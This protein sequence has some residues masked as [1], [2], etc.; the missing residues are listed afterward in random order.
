M[1]LYGNVVIDK[2][3]L[4]ANMNFSVSW[5]CTRMCGSIY[6][7]ILFEKFMEYTSVNTLTAQQLC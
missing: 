4:N 1:Y 3:K 5:L 2:T 6:V 7:I